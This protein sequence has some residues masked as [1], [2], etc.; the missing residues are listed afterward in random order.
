MMVNSDRIEKDNSCISKV[1]ILIYLK[2]ANEKLNVTSL[3]VKWSI[4]KLPTKRMIKNRYLNHLYLVKYNTRQI[5]ILIDPM[6][7]FQVKNFF[8]MI[9]VTIV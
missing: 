1:L 5:I 8:I 4:L 3:N 9:P 7:M 2:K 6:Y